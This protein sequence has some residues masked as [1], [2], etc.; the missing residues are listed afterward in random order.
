MYEAQTPQAGIAAAQREQLDTV[1]CGLGA[2]FLVPDDHRDSMTAAREPLS[3]QRLLS[4]DAPGVPPA[5]PRKR[6]ER[7]MRDET[8]VQLLGHLLCIGLETP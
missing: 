8:E 4:L 3:H 5:S 2:G 1:V 6:A 7:I